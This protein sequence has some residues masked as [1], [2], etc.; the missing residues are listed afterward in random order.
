LCSCRSEKYKEENIVSKT[1]HIENNLYPTAA[2]GFR[3]YDYVTPKWRIVS[4]TT[5]AEGF[6]TYDYV[7]PKF[8][9][10]RKTTAAELLTMK[11]SSNHGNIS[12]ESVL[13]IHY[14]F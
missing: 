1:D 8:R 12:T 11:Y 14:V 13:F 2:E 9:I 7:T 6:R 4:K 5:A 10:V 3:T